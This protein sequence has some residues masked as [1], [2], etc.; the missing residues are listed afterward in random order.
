MVCFRG[1]DSSASKNPQNLV[2]VSSSPSGFVVVVVV[3]LRFELFFGKADSK[4]HQKLPGKKF[5]AHADFDVQKQSARS[6]IESA[7]VF[8]SRFCKR[9]VAGD[10]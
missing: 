5:I 3:L 2:L 4:K 6:R 8:L 1:N 9:L 10:W 7:S